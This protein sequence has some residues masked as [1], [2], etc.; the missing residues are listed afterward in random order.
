MCRCSVSESARI[1]KTSTAITNFRAWYQKK[2]KIE[3]IVRFFEF[4]IKYATKKFTC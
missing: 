2:K 3:L 1:L 4:P